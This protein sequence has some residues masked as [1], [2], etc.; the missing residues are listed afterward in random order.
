MKL[1][2]VRQSG[3]HA[4]SILHEAG[5]TQYCSLYL[6]LVHATF[7]RV[8]STP[9]TNPAEAACTFGATVPSEQYCGYTGH[10][11]EDPIRLGVCAVEG[12]A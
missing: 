12:G 6:T 8:S 11:I 1:R 4:R 7:S 3:Q 5:Y 9:D 2:P 10:E